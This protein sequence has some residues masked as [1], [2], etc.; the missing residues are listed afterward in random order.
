NSE[1]IA[2]SDDKDGLRKV[3]VGLPKWLEK[4]LGYP[5]TD[6]PDPFKCHESFGHHMSALLREAYDKCGI[7]YKFM[8]AK[9]VYE[10]GLLNKEI[11]EI[12]TNA[13]KVGKI[14]KEEVGQEKYLEVLPYFAVCENCGRIYTTKVYE[15]LPKERKVLY[16]CE[17]M[18]VKGKWLEGCGYKGEADYT[19]GEGKLSWKG[20][21]AARWKALDIRFEAYGKDIADSVRVNDRICQEILG[22]P[23]P[24]HARYEMFLDKSGRKISKSIGNV[25]TPQVWLR[26]GSPQSLLLLTLKRFTGTRTLDVTDIPQYMM[27]LDELEDIYFGRKKITDEMERAKLTGLYKYCW[28]LKPP[29]KPSIH[30]PYNLLVY[31][32]KIAPKGKEKEFIIEKLRDYRYLGKD[33][34][35]TENLLK[36]IEYALNWTRDYAEEIKETAIQLSENEKKAI[37]GLIETIRREEAAEKIQNAIFQIAKENGIK[38]SEFFKTLYMILLGAPRGPRLGPYIIAMG[39]ENV[40]QALEK[41]L[42]KV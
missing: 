10:R 26:Y 11:E 34:K 21:F 19:K 22:F 18:E 37:K 9:E 12:L 29:E 8:S 23:P 7:E 31:L 32:A 41:A 24:M 40:I 35:P 13:K 33:E 14:V 25:F 17:G 30:V 4:Y 39:R 27:E 2:F 20:E 1:L 36:R 16:V 38:P 3:P 5:V 15:F 42:K 6:I 28:H